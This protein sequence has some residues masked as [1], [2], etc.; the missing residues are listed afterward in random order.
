M[1][2]LW[3]PDAFGA[4][5]AAA[6]RPAYTP[7]NGAGDP[8]TWYQDCSSPTADDGTEWRAAAINILLAQLR[9]AVRKS[10]QAAT[11]LDDLLLTAAIRSQGSN[12]RTAGGTANAITVTLDPAPASLAALEGTP[13]RVK[14]ATTNT[15]GTVTLNVN[16]LGATAVKKPGGSNP[17]IGDLAAGMIATVV[18]T[19]TEFMLTSVLAAS[20]FIPGSRGSQSWSTAGTYTFTVPAGVYAIYCRVLGGGGG[21]GS[22]VGSGATGGGAGGYDEG[23]FAVTPGEEITVTVGAGGLGGGGVGT[24]ASGGTTSIGTLISAT[25][26]TGGSS[27]GVTGGAGGVGVG[28]QLE[29]QAAGGASPDI[30]GSTAFGG[31]GGISWAGGAGQ[32]VSS[33]APGAGGSGGTAISA[34]GIPGSD[35]FASIAW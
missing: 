15:S 19:G 12:Y 28:G 18:Y 1:V 33:T 10:G 20:G 21:G 9:G 13:L 25:G 7:D 5:Q 35:G 31:L 27:D 3:G 4:A 23:W 24:G 8:D 26:G 22:N 17:A 32:G 6:S 2:D 14:I 16:A 29:L 11:N 34:L 30:Y